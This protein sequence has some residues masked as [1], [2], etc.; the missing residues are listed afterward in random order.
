[1]VIMIDMNGVYSSCILCTHAEGDLELSLGQVL[2]FFTGAE[3]PPPLGFDT[4]ASMWFDPTAEF[5]V[6]ST[7]ALQL[8]LP[9]KYFNHPESFRERM[10]YALQNH[11]GFGM[12]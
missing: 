11:G 5:P 1:M 2:S 12:L 9:T 3:Y 8:T 10:L 6:A 4:T 7:C